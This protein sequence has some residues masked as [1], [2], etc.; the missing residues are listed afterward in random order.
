MSACAV[1]CE[2]KACIAHGEFDREFASGANPTTNE[3]RRRKEKKAWKVYPD[4]HRL[5][6]DRH[7]LHAPC[8]AVGTSRQPAI[9]RRPGITHRAGASVTQVDDCE[10]GWV[11]PTG[12]MQ[13]VG[14]V[15]VKHSIM[16][17]WVG[18]W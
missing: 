5:C 15:V 3:K 11:M 18:W 14:R 8:L 13:S 2:R 4:G 16:S 17:G 9:Q 6:T 10:G 12:A 1:A 7:R